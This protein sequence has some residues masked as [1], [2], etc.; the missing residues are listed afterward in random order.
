MRYD[1]TRAALAVV[2]WPA[3]AAGQGF[4]GAVHAQMLAEGRTVDVV[5]YVK[6]LR[7]RTEASSPEIQKQ[8]M[9]PAITIT[10]GN[11]G[12]M[13]TVV[14]AQKMYMRTNVREMAK[15]LDA[16]DREHKLPDLKFQRTGRKE[17]IAGYACEHWLVGQDQTDMCIAKGLGFWGASGQSGVGALSKAGFLERRDIEAQL[18][19]HPELREF[20]E[21][22]AFPLKI[23]DKRGK[24]TM[25]VTRI[26]KKR[27]GDDL[28]RPPADYQ[29]MNLGKAMQQMMKGDRQKP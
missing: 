5:Y 12:E 10:D 28:F 26:E 19:R 29:E 24:F 14:P 13:I 15:G 6:G 18:A 27:I 3:P 9:G 16:G 23:Q 22:G 2:A 11:T 20:A 8:Y 4:E 1:I 7:S 25:V 21:D 17:T